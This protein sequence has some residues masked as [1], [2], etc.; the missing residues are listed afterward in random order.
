MPRVSRKPVSSHKSHD[1]LIGSAED[2]YH[3]EQL[4]H[5]LGNKL[6]LPLTVLRSL[7]DGKRVS[8]RTIERAIR[9]LQAIAE[10]FGV[11]P[12]RPG[13]GSRRSVVSKGQVSPDRER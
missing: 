8:Q 10:H 6:T 1:C 2:F 13:Q 12:K 4:H 7:R 5:L 9:D 3:A 11:Q